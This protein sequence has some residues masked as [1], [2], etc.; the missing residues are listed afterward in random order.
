MDHLQNA[1]RQR[2]EWMEAVM[3][4][5][6]LSPG[7]KL[8]A[9]RLAAYRNVK[10]G[11]CDPSVPTIAAGV[12]M[13]ERNVK[14]VLAKLQAQGRI[15]RH[16]GGHGPRDTTQYEL[17]ALPQNERADP[18]RV[19]AGTPLGESGRVNV[20]V[21]RVNVEDTKGEFSSAKERTA[22]HPNLENNIEENIGTVCDGDT[23]TA[24]DEILNGKEENL[25]DA[26]IDAHFEEF[27]K[28]CPRAV[29][30]GKARR[31]YREV[32]KSGKA[33]PGKLLHAIMTGAAARQEADQDEYT[34]PPAKWLAEEWWDDDPR[35]HALDQGEAA[36]G[37]EC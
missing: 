31:E 37:P 5:S 18:K 11:R 13:T 35:A 2:W 26:Q 3:A 22:G 27:W 1:H 36:G 28:Q 14:K 30:R 16:M 25:S 15:R 24:S 29:E 4:D 23:R 21:T 10:T 17:I 33:A 19:N 20:N 8:V 6:N 7:E 9:L 32:I 34:K 12:A